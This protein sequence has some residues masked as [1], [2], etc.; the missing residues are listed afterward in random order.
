MIQGWIIVLKFVLRSVKAY[1]YVFFIKKKK[2][3][4]KVRNTIFI[5]LAIAENY[6][7]NIEKAKVR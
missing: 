4:K 5:K 3:N 7:Q 1:M 2:T 6:V